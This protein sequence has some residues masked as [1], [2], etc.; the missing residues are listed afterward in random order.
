VVVYD[1][2]G[3]LEPMVSQLGDP[4]VRHVPATPGERNS[5]K[6][7]SALTLCRGR[8]LGA[9]DDDDRYAPTFLERVLREF[10]RDPSVGVVF[11]NHDFD[12]G[13]RRVPRRLRFP[14]GTHTDM[15]GKLLRHWPVALSAAMLRRE[16]WEEGER[17]K[18]LPDDVW[19]DRFIW[20][21]T[22]ELGWAF[23][24]VD[25][26]LMTYRVHQHQM[27]SAY[28]LMR[29]PGVATLDAFSFA[30]PDDDALRREHLADALLARAANDLSAGRFERAREDIRRAR[31]AAPGRRRSRATL[32][33]ALT[34]FPGVAPR[35]A[36]VWRRRP[37]LPVLW[38]D[39]AAA[40]KSRWRARA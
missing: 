21:R 38:A 39:R 35:A 37:R 23:H 11:T 18:P 14:A 19:A 12:V 36:A 2:H 33:R 16:A 20:L 5:A 25:E 29:E 6:V 3:G 7:R 8:Y 27:S 10:E 40:L 4:R 28:D 26:S 32:L 9:L 22:A 34:A 31:T 24:Y 1:D 30:D 13:G 17:V 15:I